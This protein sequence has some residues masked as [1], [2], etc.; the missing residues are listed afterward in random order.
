MSAFRLE[1]IQ[2]AYGGRTVL[3]VEALE[4][5]EG[6]IT[7][8]L[9]P[10]GA[11]KTTL[12]NILAFLEAPD[13]GALWF[14]GGQVDFR[15]SVLMPLR[16]KVVLIQQNPVMFS[17]SVLK[18]LDFGLRLRGMPAPKRRKRIEESLDLVGMGDF[19]H[20]RAH[21][22]S[23]GETQRVALAR[24][25]ALQPSVILCDEPAANVDAHNQAAIFN[26][27]RRVNEDRGAT[28]VFTSH[29]LPW[30]RSLAHEV[31]Y[32]LHGRPRTGAPENVYMGMI[33][34]LP[35]GTTVCELSG[36]IHLPAPGHM[37]GSTLVRIDPAGVGILL[38]DGE[39]TGG[40]RAMD[41]RVARV[42]LE[43]E[44]VWVELDAGVRVGMRLGMGEYRELAPMA[45]D[46]V[47]VAI[48][49]EAVS[50]D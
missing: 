29:D 1:N 42:S 7:A 14:R 40:R 39:P 10:N 3:D 38:A 32:M 27:L 2:R 46:R 18:N 24:A 16:R 22:L 4:I 35:D 12:F 50:F 47:R 37:P 48:S 6:A 9:G 20:A 15:E 13:S 25:L 41:A 19:L 33:R 28:L 11:G 31:V 43:G 34:A 49:P 23:G 17:T 44:S 21:R 45:G 5:R 26:L 36:G 30:A 8:L